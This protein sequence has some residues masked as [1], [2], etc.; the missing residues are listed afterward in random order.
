MKTLE[1]I[2]VLDTS[3]LLPGAYCSLLLKDLGAE[4]I[5]IEDPV[6]G[7]YMRNMP[8]FLESGVSAPFAMVNRGKKS[9]TLNIKNE[10]ERKKLLKLIEISD[11]FI[12]SFRPGVLKKYGLDYE[13]LKKIKKDLIYCSL[14]GYGQKSQNKNLASHDL[15]YLCL[16]GFI[17]PVE[18]A[19]P[20]IPLVQLGDI[21]GGSLMAALSILSALLKKNQSGEG[22]FLDI[23]IFHGAL[24]LMMLP[25]AN[26][27]ASQTSFLKEDQNVRGGV[28]NYKIYQT[29]DG[30]FIGFCP[31]EKKFMNHFLEEVGLSQLKDS[32]PEYL[33]LDHTLQEDWEKYEKILSTLFKERTWEEWESYFKKSDVCLTPIYHKGEAFK[34]YQTEAFIYDKKA[35]FYYLKTVFSHH[36]SEN[37]FDVPGLGEHT[38]EVLELTT[39]N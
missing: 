16:S 38:E 20:Q 34:N 31:V 26:L 22:S 10:I 18:D 12:E 11:V 29:K 28:P 36:L 2:R 21:C 3:R 17:H 39:S 23:S 35:K 9:V 25:F 27:Q 1:N 15:N 19:V 32:F 8:P 30:R 5:K 14:S 13:S 24:S 37:A 33:G 4:I 7:D 6:R